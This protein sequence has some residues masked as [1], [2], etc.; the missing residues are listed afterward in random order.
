MTWFLLFRS[1]WLQCH[2][3]VEIESHQMKALQVI[4]YDHKTLNCL[5]IQSPF[6][7][8]TDFWSVSKICLLMALVSPL[9]L[10]WA[11]EAK[12]KFIHY[13]MQKLWNWVE[14]KYITL[15]VMIDF[16]R[17][18]WQIINFHIKDIVCPKV[19]VVSDSSSIHL[20]SK[21]WA[22]QQQIWWIQKIKIFCEP[23]WNHHWSFGYKFLDYIFSWWCFHSFFR[24]FSKLKLDNFDLKNSHKSDPK[25]LVPP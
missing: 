24:K 10:K 5:S 19:M 3:Q 8:P 12:C 7:S 22:E 4:C 6:E 15:S 17:P 20:W 11:P 23:Q 9:D 16:G 18:I 1:W 25:N 14:S 2:R 21:C 13:L